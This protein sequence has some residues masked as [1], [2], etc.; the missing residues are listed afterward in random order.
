MES[1]STI[2]HLTNATASRKGHRS[3]FVVELHP[4]AGSAVTAGSCRAGGKA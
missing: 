3:D 2:S 4:S 1:H